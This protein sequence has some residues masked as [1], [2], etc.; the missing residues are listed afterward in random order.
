[1]IRR[2]F[3]CCLTLLLAFV[4]QAAAQVYHAPTGQVELFCGAR[5][6]YA[7]TNWLRLYDVQINATPGVRWHLG[8]EWTVAV[9][10][11]IP[12]VSKG[13]T[14]RDIHDK[15]NRLNMAV[16]S[17][18]LHFDEAKQHLRLSAGWFSEERYG[19]D[20]RWMWPATRWLLLRAQA[21][22]TAYWMLGS[23]F[24]GRSE[25]EMGKNFTFTGMAGANVYLRP[26]DVEVRASGGRYVAGDYG[27]QLDVMRHFKHCT[28]LMFAQLRLGDRMPSKWD[29]YT[30]RTN[31]GFQVIMMLPP[32]KK[33][34][35]KLVVRPASYFSLIN[36]VRA[37]G[38]SML[39]YNTDPEENDRELMIDV[40]W[41][42]GS[43]E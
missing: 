2:L 34:Q 15:Y 29:S 9:Q 32:Y 24:K 11:L 42:V 26:W 27:A 40:D 4:H 23:D 3:F 8:K 13:Y 14:F 12:V 36:N 20:V 33:S 25:A 1:M 6:G 28:L 16:V 43:E 19:A 17:K 5:L 41:G 31:G 22:L 10:G 30:H 21:G 37:D 38:Q 18:Q 7:D 39:M 35:K